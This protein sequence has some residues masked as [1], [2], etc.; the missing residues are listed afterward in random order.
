MAKA[1]VVNTRSY[2][3]A[4]ILI[5]AD[6][7]E[8]RAGDPKDRDDPKWLRREARQMRAYALKRAEG[9]IKK[10]DERRKNVKRYGTTALLSQSN[11]RTG[12]ATDA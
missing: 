8:A 11:R 2:S 1:R 5:A 7:L 4:E 9:R 12:S 6:K 3:A 10:A